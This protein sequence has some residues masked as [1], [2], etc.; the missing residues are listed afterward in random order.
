MAPALPKLCPVSPWLPALWTQQQHRPVTDGPF[1]GLNGNCQPSSQVTSRSVHR[2]LSPACPLL[3]LHAAT[4]SPPP[5]CCSPTSSSTLASINFQADDH[6][7][8]SSSAFPTHTRTRELGSPAAQQHSTAHR[9][10]SAATDTYRRSCLHRPPSTNSLLLLL[11][12]SLPR[13][14]ARVR[15]RSPIYLSRIGFPCIVFPGRWPLRLFSRSLLQALRAL[16]MP[17]L[18]CRVG[19]A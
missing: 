7:S 19:G 18:C 17:A 15:V 1:R 6:L 14:P 16:S 4:N 3:P 5:L 12:T 11:D 13:Q 9:K 8:P 2:P 10:R